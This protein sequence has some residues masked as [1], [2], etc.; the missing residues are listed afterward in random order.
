MQ[1]DFELGGEDMR[2]GNQVFLQKHHKTL[3][4]RVIQV[5]Q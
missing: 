3:R 4:P 2:S 1:D 5:E